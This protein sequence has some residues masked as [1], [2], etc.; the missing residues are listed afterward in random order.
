MPLVYTAIINKIKQNSISKIRE[1]QYVGSGLGYYDS[2][3][4]SVSNGD[5]DW[6]ISPAQREV[7]LQKINCFAQFIPE[8]RKY[9]LQ[10]CS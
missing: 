9:I 8:T 3:G 10:R 5:Y 1:L 2:T 7:Y 4:V 6:F